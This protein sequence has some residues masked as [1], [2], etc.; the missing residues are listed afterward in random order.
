MKNNYPDLTQKKI[1]FALN[2]Q[3]DLASQSATGLDREI[4]QN[5]IKID[6][7]NLFSLKFLIIVNKKTKIINIEKN[8]KNNFSLKQK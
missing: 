7:I 1:I 4:K 8:K 6:I 3:I 5:K 2:S